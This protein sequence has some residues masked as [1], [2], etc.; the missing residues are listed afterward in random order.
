MVNP[1]VLGRCLLG[2]WWF[3]GAWRGRRVIQGK[4]KEQKRLIDNLAA[5]YQEIAKEKGL[6]MGDFP[7][8]SLMRE[9]LEKMDFTKFPKLDKK[10]PEQKTG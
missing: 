7:D 10:T 1:A 9:K 2:I 3:L 4:S 8:P 5:V 6:A